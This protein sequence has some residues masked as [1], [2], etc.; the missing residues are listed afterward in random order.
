[1]IPFTL[2]TADCTGNL[3]NCIYPHKAIIGHEDSFLRAIKFDHVAAEFKD[4]Y[5]SNA[6]FIKADNVVLDCDND[7][8]DDPQDWVTSEDVAKT[9][10][11]VSF[12]V[13]YS[14]N[15]MKQKRNKSARPRFH[16]YFMLPETTDQ[17]E[18]AMLKQQ[19]AS[20]FPYFD[21]NALD[22]ARLIFGTDHADVE[23][24]DGNKDIFDF[25]EDAA[26]MDWD[27]EQE[28]VPEGKRN[29]AMS[30]FAGKISKRYGN[31]DEAYTL[32]LKQAKRCNPPLEEGEL[33]LIWNSAANFGKRVASQE[34]YIP[35]EVYNSDT[36][37]MPEDFS[38]VGQAVVLAREYAGILRYSPATDYIVY[39]GSVWEESKSKSQAVAQELTT[40]QLEEAEKEIKK[41]M[42]E[43]VK[44][45][46]VEILASMGS[47]KA[48]NHFNKQ[49]SHAFNRYEDAYAYKKYAIKR[50]DS[51]YITSVLKEARPML[52]IEQK[53]LDADEFLLN[54]TSATYDLREGMKT[55]LAHDS[56][57]FITKQT[58]VDPSDVGA[59]KWEDVLNT[60]FLNDAE[61][62]NYVQKIVGLSSI[63]KVYVEALIIAYGEGRNGKSTFWNVV[64]RI[65][66]S[67]SGNLSADMLTVGCRRNVKPE[68]AEAKGK[69]M[70]IAAEM[71]EGMR[72]NTSNVKQLCSTDEIYAEK[73]YKDP[74]SYTPS[75]TL[76]LYTNHLPKVGAI[77]KGTWR[78][79]IV[80]PFAAKIE[81]NQ[82][83]KNYADYLF[84]HSAGAILAWIIEGAKKVI[85]DEYKIEPPQKVKDAIQEY[86][87]NNDW[88]S[89]FLI[90]CCE[91][92]ITFTAKSGEVYKEYRAFCTR[93][94]EYIRSTTDFYIALDASGFERHKRR[95]GIIVRGLRLKSE[96]LE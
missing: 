25:L 6:N 80:I 89:H 74:F 55:N 38:D 20:A 51:K 52:E 28:E 60:F 57:H 31:T 26:F 61:L 1:M 45:G 59:D 14:R 48:V 93:T 77:D 43:M 62:I 30:H 58:A 8:S 75:H 76:V 33:N 66:G 11:D 49:Q 78:R 3:S 70:L 18:Y 81:G 22:S 85:K 44:N 29:S 24:Y 88:L 86:K 54:T 50:R 27:N 68:L 41:A 79:L 35:P 15:H 53:M 10:S 46:A 94:G 13:S 4:N 40:R 95:A 39:S 83:I 12:V 42:A 92:D 84:E 72:L 37:L 96:F 91:L 71:E 34:G 87:E 65:L 63:G 2:Y 19:I 64:S 90:E 16:V 32:F 21:T 82:D 73:K 17:D 23:F 5:R 47:K 69:R 56:S 67:Y 36:L 7:H 9:F